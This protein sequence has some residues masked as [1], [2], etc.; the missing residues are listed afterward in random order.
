MS[1]ADDKPLSNCCS[2]SDANA[3]C[4]GPN[5]SGKRFDIKALIFVAVMLA[6]MGVGIYS[7]WGKSPACA[8]GVGCDSLGSSCCPTAT[9]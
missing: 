8:T 9:K 3:S 4:C 2:G 6:A 7:F 5:K 1:D